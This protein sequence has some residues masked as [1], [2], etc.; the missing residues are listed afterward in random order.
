MKK[1]FKNTL[2]GEHRDAFYSLFVDPD[3]IFSSG[4]EAGFSKK[5]TLLCSKG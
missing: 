3:L 1:M 2:K 4:S 5:K